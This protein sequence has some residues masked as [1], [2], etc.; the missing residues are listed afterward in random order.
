MVFAVNNVEDIINGAIYSVGD[1]ACLRNCAEEGKLCKAM[2][3]GTDAPSITLSNPNRVYMVRKI[4][5]GTPQKR[6]NDLRVCEP[7]IDMAEPLMTVGENDLIDESEAELLLK[8]YEAYATERQ[9]S[10]KKE[11]DIVRNNG[12]LAEPQETGF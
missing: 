3:F 11:N 12:K 1:I 8:R 4:E 10:R 9:V 6:P 5:Y 2:V 7:L